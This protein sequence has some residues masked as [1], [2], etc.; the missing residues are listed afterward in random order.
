V[1]DDIGGNEPGTGSTWSLEINEM[2]PQSSVLSSKRMVVLDD[3][4]GEVPIPGSADVHLPA[5]GLDVDSRTVGP[6]DEPVPPR[7]YVF[8][9]QTGR[10]RLK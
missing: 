10:L 3:P 1:L 2:Y 8:P 7:R 6:A 4:C 5:G 9:D